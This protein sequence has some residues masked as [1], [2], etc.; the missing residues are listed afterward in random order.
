[1]GSGSG[2][3]G[4][5]VWAWMRQSALIA[6]VLAVG[7]L[8]GSVLIAVQGCSGSFFQCE[9]KAACPASGT[10]GSTGTTGSV[11]FAFVSYTTTDGN[12]VVTGYDLASGGL[13]AIN[14]VTLPFVPIA[15]TVNPANSRLYVASVPGAK[16][17]GI[18]EYTIGTDGTLTS[19]GTDPLVQD[20]PGAMAISPDGAWLFTLQSTGQTMTEYKVDATTGSLTSSGAL[21]VPALSCAPSVGTPVL[22]AC[23]IAVSPLKELCCGF[24]G[25]LWR[26]GVWVYDG[27]PASRTTGRSA[28]SRRAPRVATF[29]WRSMGPTTCTLR[30]RRRWRCMG[31]PPRA[32]PAGEAIR[33]RAEAR[34]AARWSIPPRSL[35]IRP[36]WARGRLPGLQPA[37]RR[38]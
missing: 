30:G 3:S 28:R 27:K 2:F 24:A 12:S 35:C 21:I 20:F 17:P 33:T 4:S 32:T 26:R 7:G 8:L 23:S 18:Y 25:N 13:T 10:T 6:V 38:R 16:T 36:T 11:D 34:L 15:M 1:M 29:P 19:A 31:W 22:P 14:T 37:R 9:N 5:R